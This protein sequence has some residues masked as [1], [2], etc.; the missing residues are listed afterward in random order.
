MFENFPA[1]IA[2]KTS[3]AENSHG[4]D[5][6]W[7]VVYGPFNDPTVAIAVIVEQG[8]YGSDS[9]AP[10][11]RKIMEAAFDLPPSK[12]AAD[13]LAEQ[14]SAVKSPPPNNNNN[15]KKQ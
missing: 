7:F 6:G 12:D 4:D 15:A 5:H 8:G 9:A 11:A 13:E 14:E 1:Q 3:T 2:G 10:I